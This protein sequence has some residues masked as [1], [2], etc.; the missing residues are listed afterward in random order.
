MFNKIIKLVSIKLIGIVTLGFLAFLPN[1]INA[2]AAGVALTVSPS[3]VSVSTSTNINLSYTSTVV[4]GTSNSIKVGIPSGYT[5]TP[6]FTINGNSASSAL[7]T[8]AGYNNYILTPSVSVSVG[9]VTIAISGLTSPTSQGNYAFLMQ[10]S[11]GD[12]GAAFQYAGNGN[13]V[14]VRA[15]IPVNLSFVIRTADDTADTNVCDMGEL[16]V[17][18]VG[19]CEYRLKVGT[20]AANGYTVSVSTS[21]NFTNGSTSLAN[22][23][24][25][26]TG[27]SFTA[28]T[29]LY[30]AF[31]DEGSSTKGTVTLDSAY[32]TSLDGVSYVNNTEAELY[33]VSRG[34]NPSSSGDTTNTALVTHKAAIAS[35]TDAGYYT[36]DVTYTVVASF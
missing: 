18:S 24:A 2:S 29:E 27:S 28:G 9:T 11:T 15:R 5:G 36:Q 21:G 14:N 1:S 23:T 19:S 32:S 33:S 10:T 30:G 16:S 6:T 13:V 4:V 26:S 35:D 3:T 25:G 8:S 17:T 20:N 12:T 34:N 31:I 7:G 22:A